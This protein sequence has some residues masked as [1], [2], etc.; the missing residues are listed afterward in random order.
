MQE[1]SASG[2]T[3]MTEAQ[4]LDLNR[5]MVE[6]EI[7]AQQEPNRLQKLK[8]MWKAVELRNELTPYCND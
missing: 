7:G 4:I 3:N 6:L 5:R 1:V 8:L 2:L